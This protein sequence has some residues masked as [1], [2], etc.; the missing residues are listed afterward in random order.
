MKK[1]IF[2]IL[3]SIIGLFCILL[4][5]FWDTYTYAL[6]PYKTDQIM[7]SVT[8][9]DG[10]NFNIILNKLFNAGIINQPVKFKLLARIKQYDT[11]IKAG[12]YILSPSMPPIKILEILKD[13]KIHLHKVTIPEGYNLG[14][15]AAAM[16]KAG[17]TTKEDFITTGRDL[18][19]LRQKK[20][21]GKTFEGYLFPDTYFF[22]KEITSKK[23]IS[24]MV[25]KFWSKIT[26]NMKTQAKAMGLSIHQ[27][28]TIAS[29]IEKETGASFERPTI[30]SVFHNR[31]KRKM[32]LESDPTVIY[33][34]KKFNGNITKKDLKTFTPYN[35]YIIKGLPPGPIANP[36]IEAINAALFPAD[37]DFLFFVSKKDTTHKFST[38]FRDHNKAVRKYQIRKRK[39]MN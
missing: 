11:K 31:L 26:T 12:D 24:T 7:K 1:I 30:S 4:Y 38:N 16:E 20:I 37:T 10:E 25:E 39:K 5:I 8:I 33:G 28:I 2:F 19:Y 21:N 14:Q 36:G 18:S 34:I 22:P 9:L 23:I 6:K 17:F 3:I 32:R 35:T 15:I 29:I 27:I 13:G